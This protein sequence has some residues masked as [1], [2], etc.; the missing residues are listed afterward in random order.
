MIIF[1]YNLSPTLTS[2]L[3]QIEKLRADI[4]TTPIPPHLQ[5]QL[6]WTATLT[7]LTGW[8][9]LSNQPLTPATLEKIL[10][11]PGAN[12]PNSDFEKK[13]LDYRTALNHIWWSWTANPKDLATSDLQHLARILGVSF[14]RADEVTSLLAYIQNG[15]VH[16]V[17]QSAIAHAYFYPSR[18]AYLSSLL[19][20]YKHGFGLNRLLTL[21]DYWAAAKAEYLKILQSAT[22]LGQITLWLEYYSQGMVT[23]MQAVKKSLSSGSA[24]AVANRPADFWEL[25]PRQQAILTLL[26]PPTSKVTNRQ[27]Q[28]QF[29]I[30]QITASRDLAKLTALNLLIP[31]GSGRSTSYTKA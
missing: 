19:I 2:A 15:Q 30:S 1:S 13:A 3:K 8:A 9:T 24:S 21:E 10:L 28:T 29:H 20:L 4:L 11:G 18:L 6:T 14:K 26:D 25:S 31:H 17:I 23:Q 5:H 27:V 16:P 22:H 12:R 7:H